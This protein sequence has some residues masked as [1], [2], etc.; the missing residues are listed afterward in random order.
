[1]KSFP[2]L[3]RDKKRVNFK[4]WEGLPFHLQ[5]LRAALQIKLGLLHLKKKNKS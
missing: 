4:M 3:E 2:D 5:N 1:M